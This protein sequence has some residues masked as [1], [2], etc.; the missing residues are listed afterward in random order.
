M[1]FL[2]FSEVIRLCTILYNSSGF[3]FCFWC[4]DKLSGCLHVQLVKALLGQRETSHFSSRKC[5]HHFPEPTFFDCAVGFSRLSAPSFPVPASSEEASEKKKSPR[6]RADPNPPTQ[7]APPPRLR[8]GGHARPKNP[9]FAQKLVFVLHTP[10]FEMPFGHKKN[11]TFLNRYFLFSFGTPL[12]CPSPAGLEP[13]IPG[14]VSRSL[15]E[16]AC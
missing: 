10:A 15:S 1:S 3:Y 8:R 2:A 5:F 7:W 12:F 9:D 11:A 14:S 16:T 6:S 4:Q 13:T